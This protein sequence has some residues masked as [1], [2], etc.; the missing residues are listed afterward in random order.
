MTCAILMA[1]SSLVTLCSSANAAAWKRHDGSQLDKPL[2]SVA[3]LLAPADGDDDEGPADGTTP[4][5]APTDEND[6]EGPGDGTHPVATRP[7]DEG[8]AEG[9]DGG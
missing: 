6:G 9:P 7:A 1:L 5:L 2:Y 8:D 4:R 3:R